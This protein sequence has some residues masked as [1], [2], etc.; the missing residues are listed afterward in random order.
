[1]E[2]SF[3]RGTRYGIKQVRWRRLWRA[4]IQEYLT[5]TIKTMVVLVRYLKEPLR[6]V[7][8]TLSSR[9]DMANGPHVDRCRMNDPN[10]NCLAY[11]AHCWTKLRRVLTGKR[12]RSVGFE[13]TL[14][15]TAR[16]ALTSFFPYRHNS[17]F[18]F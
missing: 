15:A 3:A 13:K 14:W 9:A 8:K 16:Q 18:D 11:P 17:I 10:A 5:A 6:A 7:A 1:L 12:S 4:E 2:R